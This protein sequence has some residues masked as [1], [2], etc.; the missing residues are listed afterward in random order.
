[1]LNLTV[2]PQRYLDALG[3]QEIARITGQTTSAVAMWIKRGKFPIDALQKLL[4]HD[5]TPIHEVQPL[6]PVQPLD[7]K[8]AILIPLTTPPPPRLLD[9]FARLYDPHQMMYQRS[10]FNYLS[11][12][13]NALAAWALRIKSL[14]WTFWM[15]AGDM[16][17]PCGDAAWYKREADMP[18]VSDVYA[19]LHTIYRLLAHRLKNGRQDATIV[20]CSYVSKQDRGEPQFGGG[21]QMRQLVRQGPQDRLIE[22]PW[23]GFGGVLVHRSVFED[24][25]RTQGDEIKMGPNGVG[26][27]F[28]YEYGLFSPLDRHTPGDDV[29]FCERARRAGHKIYV[30]LA[31]QAAHFG[32]RCYSFNDL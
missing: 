9:C 20:S 10:S 12:T 17:M 30:D 24:I 23:C 8:L 16:I 7:K 22:V 4:E 5:P 13:R 3:R 21:Q 14:E 15:D 29:P 1:V 28:H 27:R 19:G 2:L 31:V 18:N 6:Y 26:S 32:D 25:I 11:V